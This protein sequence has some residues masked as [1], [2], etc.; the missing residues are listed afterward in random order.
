MAASVTEL[1]LCS[2]IN[3]IMRQVKCMFFIKNG[4]NKDRRRGMIGIIL[5]MKDVFISD[6]VGK[7]SLFKSQI[8]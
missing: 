7:L 6:S 5:K 8:P 1:E 2:P 3:G 4:K